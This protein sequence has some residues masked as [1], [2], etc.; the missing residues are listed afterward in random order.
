MAGVEAGGEVGAVLVL[1]SPGPD[2]RELED[3]DL[4]LQGR[5][6]G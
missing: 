4:R 2:A 5:P 6:P 3:G 1:R